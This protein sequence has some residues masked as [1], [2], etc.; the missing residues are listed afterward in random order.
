MDEHT[1]KPGDRVRVTRRP[2]EG[3]VHI[4][5]GVLVTV[6]PDG[7]FTLNGV[8]IATGNPEHGYFSDPATLQRMYGCEQTV[9]ALPT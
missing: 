1:Y 9:Q 2:K 6:A 5:E 8:H 7:G 4:W 3:G